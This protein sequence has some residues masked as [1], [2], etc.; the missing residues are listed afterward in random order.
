MSDLRWGIALVWLA[1]VC[2]WL[3]VCALLAGEGSR[4]RRGVVLGL[5]W[6]LLGLIWA[7]TGADCAGAAMM[8]SSGGM[9]RLPRRYIDPVSGLRLS[10]VLSKANEKLGQGARVLGAYITDPVFGR[11]EVDRI[12]DGCSLGC[13]YNPK[14]ARHK[15]FRCYNDKL[16][17]RLSM[18]AHLGAVEGKP[19]EELCFSWSYLDAVRV[20]VHGDP[21][22]VAHL[23]E[24]LH[25]AAVAN[26]CLWLAYTAHWR[27]LE[28]SDL[29]AM[30]SVQSLEDAV[31]A[32]LCGWDIYATGP[33]SLYSELVGCRGLIGP[34]YRC[35]YRRGGRITCAGGARSSACPMA[36]TG[37]GGRHVFNPIH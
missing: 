24:P 34:I 32:A 6:L 19:S 22:L 1:M 2:T 29:V 8:V 37:E 14:S 3:G 21:G 20:S 27:Q 4:V 15:G 11:S 12:W 30:A 25:A 16:H 23:L 17:G 33:E 10:W 31:E 28:P 36:C 35:P 26:G 5:I 7:L 18:Y 13:A 9:L